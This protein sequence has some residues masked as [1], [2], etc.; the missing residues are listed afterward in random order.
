MAKY[1][2]LW[3]VPHIHGEMLKLA[4]EISESTIMRYMPK[5]EGST[6]GQNWKTFLKNHSSGII[7]IDYF[8]VPTLL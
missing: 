8:C 3:G 1:N 5:K 7:S 4:I 2:P 6:T